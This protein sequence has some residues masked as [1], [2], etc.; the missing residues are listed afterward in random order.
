VPRGKAKGPGKRVRMNREALGVIL[1][2]YA[3]GMQ[4]V[5][6]QII[7]AANPRVPDAPPLGAGLVKTG[8]AVTYVEGK[9]VAGSG[10]APRGSVPRTGVTTVVGYGFPGRFQE[11]GT[12]HQPARPFFTPAMASVIPDAPKTVASRIG[13]A[14][15]SLRS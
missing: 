3:D 11:V 4:A 10:T 5:G 14:L 13:K 1:R 7:V 8:A 2:E 12:Q 6:E 15:R 9:K